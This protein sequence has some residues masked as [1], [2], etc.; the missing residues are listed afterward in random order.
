MSRFRKKKAASGGGDSSSLADMIA[1]NQTSAYE[2]LQLHKSKIS[3]LR[4]AGKFDEVSA[5]SNF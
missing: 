4:V 1:L 5:G 3:R 2:A